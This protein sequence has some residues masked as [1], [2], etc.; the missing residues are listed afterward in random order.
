[1]DDKPEQIQRIYLLLTLL[2]TLAASFIWGINTIFLLDAGLSNMEAFAANAFF[3]VG[4]VLFEV[5]TGIVADTFGRKTS[6]LLGTVTLSVSTLLYL[7]AWQNHALFWVWALTSMLLGLGFT[8]FSGAT[9]AWLVDS[10]HFTGFKGKLEEVFAKGQIVGGVAMLSGA[11]LGGVVAEKMG[12]GVPYIIRAL[13]LALTFVIAF[14]FMKDLG[15]APKK[16]ANPWKE[17][18]NTFTLSLTYGLKNPSVRGIMLAALFTSGVGFYT[19]YAMQPYL[20]SLYGNSQAYTIAGLAAAIV[21][22]AQIAGGFLA[23]RIATL[24]HRRTT[25]LL[26]GTA[27][28]AVLLL[29]IGFL[30]H[31]VVVIALLVL[32]ALISAAITPVRQAYLNDSIPSQQRATVLSFDSL[33]GSSGGVFIQPVL[34]KV[35]DVWSYSNSYVV[36]A[37]IQ[38]LALPFVFYTRNQRA[39]ADKS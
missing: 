24:F 9:E 33:I 12:L 18:K 39:K 21:A 3:T 13:V 32:W 31:F 29:A 23:P 8:F 20:L 36:G 15:F 4:Q 11:I 5:P 7:L 30:P 38:L 27:T 2:S 6:Y 17:I 22:G 34:G 1:M 26:S 25:L 19:F 35:A 16:S 14:I 28:S 37:L 10:L